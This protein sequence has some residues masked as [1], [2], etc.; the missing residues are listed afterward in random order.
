MAE[1]KCGN[2]GAPVQGEP[3]A[4][5]CPY[6]GS[7]VDIPQGAPQRSAAN[8]VE[9]SAAARK[10][11]SYEEDDEPERKPASSSNGAVVFA[12]IAVVIVVFVAAIV[13]GSR[14]R[15]KKTAMKNEG[16]KTTT[17]TATATTTAKKPSPPAF[18]ENVAIPSCRCAFGD[19][20]STPLVALTL[21]AAPLTDPSRP[22]DVRIER[23]S[24]FV[25]ESR[26]GVLS[27]PVD[28]VLVPNDAGALP[29]HL[30]VACD[31]GVYVLVADRT[32]TGW[33]SVS[34]TWKWTTVLPATMTD[35]ADASAPMPP[36]GAG[37]APFCS[38]LAT[39]SGN[40]TINLANGRKATLSLKDGKL[41]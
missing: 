35:G 40:A 39:Q 15:S 6:C 3:G 32:A 23:Q 14:S 24:G 8:V 10:H 26:S 38:P 20:Q 21:R 16:R 11:D 1:V 9:Q 22:F 33:S 29:A 28:S 27:T 18:V 34:A 5:A 4:M 41:R 13:A 36:K 31:T 7:R 30:G 19:G 37:F 25:S 12:V 17:T 2:C